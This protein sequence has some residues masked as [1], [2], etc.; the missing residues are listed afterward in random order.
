MEVKSPS[1][2]SAVKIAADLVG[3]VGQS[4]AYKAGKVIEESPE[5]AERIGRGEV[6]TEEAFRV[7]R[8]EPAKSRR[9]EINDGAA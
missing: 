1:R 2:G 5:L 8:G 9:Q 7:V 4:L 3:G 6:T